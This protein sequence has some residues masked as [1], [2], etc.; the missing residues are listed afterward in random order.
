M[1]ELGTFRCRTREGVV[2]KNNVRDGVETFRPSVLRTTHGT[3]YWIAQTPG[4]DELV[5]ITQVVGEFV[6]SSKS[7]PKREISR[8]RNH[9]RASGDSRPNVN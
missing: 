8:H 5:Q 3:R 2:M 4:R 9:H 1:T 7:L 6:N